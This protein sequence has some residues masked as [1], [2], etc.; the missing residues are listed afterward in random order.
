MLEPN[1]HFLLILY[2]RSLPFLVGESLQEGIRPFAN[3][4]ECLLEGEDGATCLKEAIVQ[5]F[6]KKPLLGQAELGNFQPVKC[7]SDIPFLGRVVEGVVWLHLQSALEEIHISH[8]CRGA[9]IGE[10]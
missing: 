7:I 10:V 5:S 6:S 1:F 8:F 3:N 2:L 4:T 9:R